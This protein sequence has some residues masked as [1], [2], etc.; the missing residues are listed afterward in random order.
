MNDT[1]SGDFNV[2][3]DFTG[4]RENEFEPVAVMPTALAKKLLT[5]YADKLV[6]ASPTDIVTCIIDELDTIA[7]S[8]RNNK[9]GAAVDA[10]TLFVQERQLIENCAKRNWNAYTTP[11]FYVEP[12]S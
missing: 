8:D 12:L 9:V 11:A 7:R 10:C 6:N 4:I 5:M 2:E 3:L 1:P